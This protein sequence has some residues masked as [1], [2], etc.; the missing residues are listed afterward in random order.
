MS[1][2][3]LGYPKFAQGFSS[4]SV[5][6]LHLTYFHARALIFALRVC[7]ES[8]SSDCDDSIILSKRGRKKKNARATS[9]VCFQNTPLS[10]AYKRP[11]L[12]PSSPP[13][14]TPSRLRC[15][16]LPV[17]PLPLRLSAINYFSERRSQSRK[18]SSFL[19]TSE[20]ALNLS[21]MDSAW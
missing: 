7:L 19:F 14:P 21:L 10:F 2:S 11:I 6:I 8:I 9:R 17:H 15:F 18:I 5:N 20:S 4:S 1:N 3:M 12:I 13:A 16:S